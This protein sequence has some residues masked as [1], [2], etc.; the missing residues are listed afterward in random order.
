[1][2]GREGIKWLDST[3]AL[4]GQPLFEVLTSSE[5]DIY[6]S[7]ARA[8]AKVVG[9][10]VDELRY[11]LR[12]RTGSEVTLW[13]DLSNIA[14]GSNWQDALR[15]ACAGAKAMLAVLSPSYLRSEFAKREY[16]TFGLEKR[17]IF[18][19]VLEEFHPD[20]HELRKLLGDRLYYEAP[21]LRSKSR[22]KKYHDFLSRLA[23]DIASTL[24]HSAREHG[25][26]LR[27]ASQEPPSKPVAPPAKGYV[28]LSYAEEDADFLANLRSFFGERGYAYWEF[29]TSDRDYQKRIDLE[30]E[31]VISSAVATVSVLSEAWKASTW[32]LRELFFSQEIGK[33]VFLVKAKPISPTLAIAGFPYIDV[34]KD[35]QQA[36]S[37][38]AKELERAGL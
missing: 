28:F 6:V 37:R 34:T 24:L 29:A 3:G 22:G 32:S 31:G 4:H 13:I 8:D 12:A 14:A 36:F 27:Q 35:E 7:Y 21:S 16:E 18:P 30:L 5:V 11:E 17:P 23:T 9:P 38:L 33:P 1:M 26:T 10:F 25:Q 15:T 19:V 20:E 2:S